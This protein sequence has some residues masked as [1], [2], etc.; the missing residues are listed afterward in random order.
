M[1][2]ESIKNIFKIFLTLTLFILIN[3]A[4]EVYAG[5]VAEDEIMPVNV[6]EENL[7]QGE[8]D[9]AKQLVQARGG[10]VEHAKIFVSKHKSSGTKHL[11]IQLHNE[12]GKVIGHIHAKGGS[13]GF[14]EVPIGLMPSSSWKSH[15][16]MS[17]DS[18]GNFKFTPFEGVADTTYKKSHFKVPNS[19]F[20]KANYNVLTKKEDL[21]KGRINASEADHTKVLVTRNLAEDETPVHLGHYDANGNLVATESHFEGFKKGKGTSEKPGYYKD[22]LSKRVWLW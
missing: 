12:V 3:A 10:D 1:N 9:Q 20:K 11:Y 13:G 6:Q 4:Q 8:I 17:K 14:K 21:A 18:S 2:K 19:K 15:I 22:V 5:T 16:Q 7:E